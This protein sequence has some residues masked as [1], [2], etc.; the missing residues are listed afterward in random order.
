MVSVA[1]AVSVG[2]VPVVHP[3]VVPVAA[4]AP[5]VGVVG[6]VPGVSISLGLSVSISGP[7]VVEG[8]VLG[9]AGSVPV[10]VHVP[11]VVVHGPVGV[12]VPV[13]VAVR[14]VPR[15]SIS[16]G[17]GLGL[18]LAV[19]LEPVSLV[20]VHVVHLPV[21]GHHG[22]VVSHPAVTPVGVAVRLVPR[23]SISL[24]SSEGG[25]TDLSMRRVEGEV[26]ILLLLATHHDGNL[27]HSSSIADN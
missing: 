22:P 7:L 3:V 4:V 12:H 19:G 13:G 17:L 14:L 10:A 23:I 11:V 24:S 25:K 5:G 6:T 9:V 16:L 8:P 20:T 15:V 21:A 1:V 2:S 26:M 18:P 27:D